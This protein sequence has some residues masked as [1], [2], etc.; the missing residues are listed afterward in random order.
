MCHSCLKPLT[1]DEVIKYKNMIFCEECLRTIYETEPKL[2]AV[3]LQ[4]DILAECFCE[5]A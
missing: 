3:I 4:E 1:K 5:F 2:M